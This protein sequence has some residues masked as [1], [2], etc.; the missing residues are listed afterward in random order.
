VTRCSLILSALA[1]VAISG[2]W[3][4]ADA[5]AEAPAVPALRALRVP[6][7]MIQAPDAVPQ[8]VDEARRLGFTAL[9]VQVRDLGEAYYRSSL[10]P[11]ATPLHL[12]PGYD[13]LG[14]LVSAAHDAGLQVHAWLPLTELANSASLPSARGHVLYT[15]PEWLMVP[16][17]I[18]A[19][20]RRLDPRSP[21]YLGRLTRWIRG[22]PGTPT[23]LYV[24]P[25]SPEASAHLAAVARELVSRYELD[26]LH[27]DAIGFPSAD[28]D[29][30][31]APTEAFRR[32][33]QRTLA[34]ADRTRLD[35]EH[36]VSPLAYPQYAP[37]AWDSFRRA[38]VTGLL[39]RIR[40][41]VKGVRPSLTVSVVVRG[42]PEVT[43]EDPRS[44]SDLSMVEA[45]ALTRSASVPP[46]S[47]VLPLT[48][49]GTALVWLMADLGA[50]SSADLLGLLRH[51]PP[52]DEGFIVTDAAALVGEDVAVLQRQQ[53]IR[54]AFRG[55]GDR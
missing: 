5:Q 10:E 35:D 11:R 34:A 2:T 16:R 29:Y 38:R 42:T 52:A 44:W 51:A 3:S 45:V 48:L 7:V 47:L 20:L 30:G 4:R 1:L 25:G 18:A 24:S 37:E 14:T 49:S 28:A 40:T 19:E 8:I 27:L 41:A 43:F 13:P 55:P 9:F 17:A 12:V 23:R 46:G 54:D 31:V 21:E 39:M 6:S 50:I 53:M 15:H 22:T 32:E 26:G 33:V 36:I